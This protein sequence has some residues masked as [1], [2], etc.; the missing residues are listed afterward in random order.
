MDDR[1]AR[2]DGLQSSQIGQP[3]AHA[4]RVGVVSL[5][6]LGGVGA[7]QGPQGGLGGIERDLG[8]A[9]VLE[10]GEGV[11][12]QQGLVWCPPAPLGELADAVE[13][14]DQGLAEGH[15]HGARIG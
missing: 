12:E 7:E 10:A 4:I 6:T 13:P 9:V 1:R 11:E 8:L 5:T 2:R 15:R 3:E 14:G